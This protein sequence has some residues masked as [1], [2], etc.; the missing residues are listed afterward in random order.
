MQVTKET[1]PTFIFHAKDDKTVP[2]ANSEQFF[3]ALQDKNVPVELQVFEEGGH[4]FGMRK[5]GIP[6]DNW[7][8]L[9]EIWLHSNKIIE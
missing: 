7:T 1:P 9:L 4:G 8:E 3:K 2:V 6:T 5:K